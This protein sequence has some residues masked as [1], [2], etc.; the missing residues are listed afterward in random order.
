[1][2]SV[3]WEWRRFVERCANAETVV[4]AAPYIKEA[5]LRELLAATG[6]ARLRCVSSWTPFEIRLG[7]SDVGCRA[8]VVEA[9]GRFM[10]HPRLHAKYYRADDLVLV[11]S[12]NL[13]SSGLGLGASPNLEILC[14]PGADFDRT[15]FE[16]RLFAESREVTDEEFVLWEQYANEEGS[17]EAR[18]VPMDLT[19]W[20]PQTRN[21]EY[22]WLAY[23]GGID[24]ITMGDQRAL[25]IHDLLAIRPP[26]GLREGEIRAWLR[27][28]LTASRFVGFIRAQSAEMEDDSMWKAVSERWGLNMADAQRLVSTS[29]IWIRWA[30]RLTAD[31][32]RRE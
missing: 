21:P 8:L 5:P 20:L 14:Q 32:T 28:S 6:A 23:S 17:S 30:S 18:D 25:A 10:L 12:A 4:I 9:S 13:T 31:D 7:S 1:M 22:I 19:D 3:S 11:G 2:N 26:H 16:T 27:D 15:T 24:D 29:Q